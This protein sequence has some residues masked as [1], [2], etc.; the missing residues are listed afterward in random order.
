VKRAKPSVLAYIPGYDS[1]TNL[2]I[3]DLVR[4]NG[5]ENAGSIVDGNQV[6]IELYSSEP[7]L[8]PMHYDIHLYNELFDQQ[9]GTLDKLPRL[10]LGHFGFNIQ[11]LLWQQ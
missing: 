11:K 2:A 6:L 7:G 4:Q 3:L 9:Y 10:W 8:Q 1:Q 5:L